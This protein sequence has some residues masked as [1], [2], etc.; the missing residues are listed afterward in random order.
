MLH[1]DQLQVEDYRTGRFNTGYGFSGEG[2][3]RK[4][5]LLCRAAGLEREWDYEN[6]TQVTF[7]ETQ[8]QAMFPL[9]QG[10]KAQV[11]SC[12]EADNP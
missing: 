10:V 2:E 1:S 3:F 8:L 4:I 11:L 6:A 5:P 12:A 9:T 7:G